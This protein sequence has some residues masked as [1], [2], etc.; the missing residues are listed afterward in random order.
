MDELFESPAPAFDKATAAKF[1]RAHYGINGTATLLVSE[2]DQN[3]RIDA[4]NGQK[5]LLKIANALEASEVIDYENA[6]LQHL[7]SVSS[8]IPTP[9]LVKTKSGKGVGELRDTE[10]SVHFARVLSWL[11]GV[12]LRSVET[13][14]PLRRQLG[15][16]LAE[17][18][19][20]L[21]GFFHPAA[22]KTIL[23][24]IT[25][26]GCLADKLQFVEDPSL[27]KLCA[28]FLTHFSEEILPRLKKLR[29]QVIYNDLNPSNILVS[30]SDSREVTGIVDFGDTVHGPLIC[31]VAV[32][33]A[34]QIASGDDPLSG[35]LDFVSAYHAVVPLEQDEIEVLLDLIIARAV[36]TIVVTSWRASI[37]PDNKNYI[38]RNT[39]AAA[40]S[41]RSLAAIDR[42]VA[43]R[44]LVQVCP[45]YL[46]DASI[47]ASL[48]DRTQ[49][50]SRREK[51]LGSAYRLFYEKPLH[52]IRGN[53]VWL[54]DA[55][56]RT[57]LD[58]Y[59]NV[60]MVGHAHPEVVAALSRQA[61]T[62]N[63]HTRYL[64][65]NVLD[66][67]ERLLDL[68]PVELNRVMFG[69]TGSEANELAL[70]IARA[71]TGNTGVIATKFAYH[72][73]TI[74]MSQISPSYSSADDRADW[75]ELIPPPDSFRE[76]NRQSD[77]S[78]SS[79]IFLKNIDSAITRLAAKGVA[80]AALILDAGFTSDGMFLPPPGLLA[81]A[82]KRI[83]AA[84][85]VYIAD[86]VQ[87][88][89]A[90]FGDSLW[91]F[92]RHEFVPEIVTLG[93]P[94]GNGHPLAATVIRGDL[95]D[96]F[97]AKARY[98]NTFG[99]NPVSAAVG[100]A[101]LNVFEREGLAENSQKTGRYLQQQLEE[102]SETH[103]MIGNIRGSGLFAGVELVVDGDCNSKAT[104]ATKRV[105]NAMRENGVLI[106]M[107]G[108]SA[109]V[110][111]I[112]PPLPF[113][114]N[115]VDHLVDVLDRCLFT[116]EEQAAA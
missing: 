85:G 50:I 108:P 63:T 33:A 62:L 12:S 9:R 73:N 92:E 67:A 113:Q 28:D 69:C 90:R 30:E 82:A 116:I 36:T 20:N 89:F 66:Y 16:T 8:K 52:A 58:A 3:F 114:K 115:H 100:L 56:G 75:V 49:I 103:S 47:D 110:L 22:G 61:A 2:R 13:S 17:L 14:A 10:N 44:R 72:G 4:E 104:D 80:P 6:I 7:Q 77:V 38:L 84:G 45:L 76:G 98:F 64:H 95:L 91:G 71:Y 83:R 54:Y 43:R 78:V 65:D 105:V 39:A 18:G 40:E 81:A 55:S 87:A 25:K 74:A 31:D 19:K 86:E 102:L 24:D 112:R 53:G 26:A 106:S 96:A 68:F 42:S 27:R 109:N 23:W 11:D 32:A 51:L 21:R 60:P 15:A 37:H 111:K 97:A 59:N 29:A 5:Y 94:M 88:G 41:V 99:G 1:V 57:Y 70:R 46:P 101:V 34:Y 79:S 48:T 93:K 107:I 35:V